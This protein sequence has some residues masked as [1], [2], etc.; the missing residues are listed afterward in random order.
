MANVLITGGAGF[1][2]SNLAHQL[3]KKGDKVTI[4]DDLSMGKMDNIDDIDVIFYKH[5]VCDYDFIHQLL[6]D[7]QFD[8]IFWLAAVASVADS[9]ERPLQTHRINQESVV[10]ALDYI[11]RKEIPIKRFL[12]TSSAAVYG[13]LSDFPKREDSHVQPLTTYAIDKYSAERF[14]V[15]FGNLY[16]LP[17]VATRFFNVYGPRQNPESPYSGVLSLV[18]KA[19]MGSGKFTVYG[20]GSQ[21]RDFIYVDDVVNALITIAVKNDE[22]QVFNI[23]NGKETS[24]L[25]VI[26]TY[27]KVAGKQL[28]LDYKNTRP[29][30]IQNS[31][32]DI[33]RVRSLGFVPKWSLQDGLEK[34]W[35]FNLN[36][37]K[38]RRVVPNE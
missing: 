9:V 16:G 38:N 12:F 31:M 30:D 17:T 15:D 21:T 37:E 3:V 36:L 25:H 24:L 10:N 26:K 22:P 6:D 28:K 23:A 2:G 11:R 29:G 32:A 34:Y 19:L 14:T 18:T 4:V 8:Y 33:S 27:E 7:G 35:E 13:N 5:D 1:I 20:D